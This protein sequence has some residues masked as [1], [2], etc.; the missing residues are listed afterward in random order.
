[1]PVYKSCAYWSTPNPTFEACGECDLCT[2]K[3]L[4]KNKPMQIN[5]GIIR[6]LR[7]NVL[8]THEKDSFLEVDL[9]ESYLVEAYLGG[10]DLAKS[11]FS[12]SDLRFVCLAG[13]DCRQADFTAC[14]M[15]G[16]NCCG[17]DFT[18]AELSRVDFSHSRIWGSD[19]TSAKMTETI[20]AKTSIK[21]CSFKFA[22]LSY[23]DFRDSVIRN[24]DFEGAV[25]KGV[26]G[27]KNG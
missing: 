11:N 16:S 18:H 12:K 5:L 22:D 21:N 8:Y 19:F 25:L 20:Y 2:G 23:A 4:K 14:N 13:S 9:P 27:L 26:R 3:K 1:M 7:G 10:Y 6:G 24:C 15:F 17:S